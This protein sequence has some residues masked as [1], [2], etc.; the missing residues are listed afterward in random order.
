VADRDLAPRFAVHGAVVS[1]RTDV[2]THDPGVESARER[3][4]ALRPGVPGAERAAAGPAGHR[5]LVGTAGWTDR[6]LTASGVF[7]PPRTTTAEARLRYYASRFPMVEVDSTYYA[8]PAR[9]MAEYWVERTP[10]DFVFD[11][12]AFALMTGHPAE[13]KRLPPAVRD[14][15]PPALAAKTRLYPKDFPRE[16]LDAI[17]TEFRDALAPLHEAGKLGAVLLQYPRWFLPN[18]GT[19]DAIL[20]ARDRL[21]GLPCAIEFRNRRW[22]TPHTAD[23][24]LRFLED[25]DLPLVVVD[26][27]QGLESS[28]P[29]VVA[30]TA[31]SL[32]VV[33]LHGRRD[34][35]WEKPGVSTTERYRYLYDQ[36]ELAEWVP[37]VTDLARKATATHV[38]FNNCYANYGTTNAS[39]MR[40]LLAA[41]D[42]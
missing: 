14:L 26:E 18:S 35:L 38:V 32:A 27:P 9:R 37:R 17:W 39:E 21:N 36:R 15:L 30:A 4:E 6:T 31:S 16:A 22:F 34:D 11:V 28:V 1:G 7:Y 25:H 24:T 19:K 23:R 20:E 41:P 3:A 12:K 42:D 40:D 5:I 2:A 10:S 13:T 8:L 33:R 29:P